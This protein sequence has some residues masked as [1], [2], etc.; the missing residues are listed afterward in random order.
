MPNVN[1]LE[2]L[3]NADAVG[4]DELEFHGFSNLVE[5]GYWT[6]STHRLFLPGNGW[7][8][9]L[10]AGAVSNTDKTDVGGC[11]PV[12]GGQTNGE[13]DPTFPSNVARTGQ[14]D[15]AAPVRAG[16]GTELRRDAVHCVQ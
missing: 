9:D 3:T 7:F 2:T 14:T 13:V 10:Y 6:S 16:R 11:L 5:T 15:S 8:V 4:F 12:R 1:E